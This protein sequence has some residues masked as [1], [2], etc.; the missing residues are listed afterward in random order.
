M[1]QR[2]GPSSPGERIDGRNDVVSEVVPSAVSREK[3][4][5]RSDLGNKER[6]RQQQTSELP[7]QNKAHQSHSSATSPCWLTEINDAQGDHKKTMD[8]TSESPTKSS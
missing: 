5:A 1:S 8:G 6:P 3:R 2:S 7:K 4:L